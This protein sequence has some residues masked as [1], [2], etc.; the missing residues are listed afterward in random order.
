MRTAI[1]TIGAAL[2]TLV[3]IVFLMALLVLPVLGCASGG[4]AYSAMVQASETMAMHTVCPEYLEYVNKDD[5][6]S[7]EQKLIRVN[8]VSEFRRAVT[9]AQMEMG[10]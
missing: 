2:L 4:P 7:A 8:N 6:L 5:T 1:K 10:R 3:A 9:A